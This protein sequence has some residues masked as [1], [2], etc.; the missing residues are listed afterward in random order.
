ML[1]MRVEMEDAELTNPPVA[2]KVG[3]DEE[4]VVPEALV[5]PPS[6]C[7]LRLAQAAEFTL[8]LDPI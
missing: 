7:V 3:A 2:L 8:R 1:G 4:D 6:A 5:S